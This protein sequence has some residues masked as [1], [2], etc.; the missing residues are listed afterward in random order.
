MPERPGEHGA[1]NS[2]LAGHLGGGLFLA[3]AAI[4][5][6][7]VTLPHP[8]TV[9]EEGYLYLA[10]GQ[11]LL[12]LLLLG[13][14]VTKRRA[15]AWLPTITIVG[16]IAAVTVAIYLNGER[17]GGPAVPNQIFY[18]WPAVYAGY[19]YSRRVIAL[20]VLG[21]GLAYCAVSLSAGLADATL[22]MRALITLSVVGGTAGFVHVLRLR[23]DTLLARLNHLARTDPLTSLLNRRG[24][25]ERAEI[26][27]SRAE[28]RGEPLTALLGDIDHFKR[29]ND[30]FGHAAGDETLAQIGTLLTASTRPEDVVARLGGEEFAMLLP[31]SDVG[32]ARAMA[33]RL[34][35]ELV[36]V[37]APD[38]QS[39]T[40][41]F[42]IA[43]NED[44]FNRTSHALLAA[45]DAALFEAKKRGR[46]RTV[47]APMPAPL[48]PAAA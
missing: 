20:V 32:Q 25:D 29:I 22:V 17:I 5:L 44:G 39:V 14:G 31:D 2:V 6:L 19:F 10:G 48:E 9:D 1:A 38:G 4:T 40:L 18:V 11:A 8:P 41:S 42:G 35:R 16:A 37:H 27:I 36:A 43:S 12:G 23:V 13:Y 24:F 15:R 45:A 34:Q 46:D 30:R 7:A 47:V 3:G 26:E 21:I 28:R 33:T